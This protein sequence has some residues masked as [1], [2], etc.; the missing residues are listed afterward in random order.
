MQL[1]IRWYTFSNWPGHITVTI[2]N[3]VFKVPKAYKVC[4]A[5]DQ[6]EYNIHSIQGIQLVVVQYP[7]YT[8]HTTRSRSTVFKAPK[9]YNQEQKY[10]IQSTQGIQQGAEVQ[11]SKHPRYTTRT[12]NQEQKYSIHSTQGIQ[13]GRVLSQYSKYPEYTTTGFPKLISPKAKASKTLFRPIKPT[14]PSV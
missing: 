13:L 1:S 10:S 4:R 7:Q 3:I 8:G 14:N 2:K 6:E 9:I 5:Y 12:Y 11:Y